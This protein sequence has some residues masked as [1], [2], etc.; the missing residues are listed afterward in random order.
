MNGDFELIHGS[1]SVFRD[2]GRVT[3]GVE[4][5]RAIIAASGL[6]PCLLEEM[7]CAVIAGCF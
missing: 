2:F 1:G 7:Q 4:Q 3:T 5:T 6:T